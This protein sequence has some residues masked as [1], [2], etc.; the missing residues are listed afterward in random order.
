MSKDYNY[1]DQGQ[2]FPYFILTI[3]GLI[4][5]P[6][7]YSSFAPSKQLGTSKEPLIKSSEYVPPHHEKVEAAR[8]RQAKK[9]R[10]LKRFT[11]LVLGW[12][13]FSYMC[14]LIA[15]T[16]L[17]EGKIWDPYDILGISTS[18][19]EKQIKSHYKRMS[20]KFHPDKIR[21]G[22]NETMEML[23]DRFVEITKAYKALTDEEIRN[24]YIQYGHPDGKQSFSIG[25]ALPTWIVA[26]GNTYYVLAVYGLLF[27]ILLPYFVGKWWYGTK[28][29]TKDGVMYESAGRLFKEYD[30]TL[31]EERLVE[32]LTVGDEIK[33]I[34]GG[35]NEKEWVNGEDATVEKKL[36]QAGFPETEMKAL[37]RHEGWRRRALG[38]LWAYLYRID[39]GSDKLDAAKL[40]VAAAAIALNR[41]FN[42]I[43]LAFG[44]LQPLIS[45]IRLSQHIIQAVVPGES[46]LLQVPHFTPS[47]VSAIE[48]D[49]GKNH[50]SVQRLMSLPETKRKKLCLAAGLSEPEYTTAMTFAQALPALK[51]EAAFFKVMG[52]K[53]ITPSSLVQFVMKVRI[54]PPGSKPPPVH[55]KDLL[56]EDPDETDVE[57]LLG[58]SSRAPKKSH[59]LPLAHAPFY[60]R[61]AHPAW[62]MFLADVR[63]GKLVVPPHT[64]TGFEKSPEG[65][66]VVTAKMQ[67]QAPP[68]AGEY[69]FTAMLMSDSYIGVDAAQPVTLVVS[70]PGKVERIEEVDDISDPEEDSLAGQMNA[71]RGGPVKKRHVEDEDD[72][73]DDDDDEEDSDTDGEADGVSD[74]DTETED[75]S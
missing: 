14:Y 59:D 64:I 27:G 2:F 73:E 50:W 34:T 37:N 55:P 67:F 16:S 75:E 47:I 54:V 21:P 18:A 8:R 30:E 11:A 29:F 41:S 25:I 40:D 15:T 3:L 28:K 31:D 22:P 19:T 42:S 23:N 44:N 71:M 12:A 43:S 45:S 72:D 32:A 70:D 48:Q 24:N 66:T 62:H 69:G 57:A 38:L 9:E 60:P 68:Q 6:I 49:G 1:D 46:P 74:T 35:V 4:L 52:E 13:A 20:L 61:D 17:V 56:D 63:Q 33:E 51:I 7:T 39:L 65:F 53:F 26:E 5:V 36:E 58:R 10:R